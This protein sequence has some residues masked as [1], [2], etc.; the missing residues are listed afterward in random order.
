VGDPVA[1]LMHA[2]HER[3]PGRRAGGTDVK[4]VKAHALGTKSVGVGRLE[5]GMS[6]SVDVSVSLVIGKNE[7]NV[8]LLGERKAVNIRQPKNGRTEGFDCH[9]S[10]QITSWLRREGESGEPKRV[11][12]SVDFEQLIPVEQLSSWIDEKVKVFLN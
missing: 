2:G 12:R 3:C 11:A 9:A 6:V 4:I 10:K 8:W 5:V 1:K 7:N